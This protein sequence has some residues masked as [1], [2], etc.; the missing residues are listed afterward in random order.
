MYSNPTHI[1]QEMTFTLKKLFTYSIAFFRSN[2]LREGPSEYQRSSAYYI[3]GIKNFFSI[4]CGKLTKFIIFENKIFFWVTPEQ[5]IFFFKI[6]L[7]FWGQIWNFVFYQKIFK[8]QFRPSILSPYAGFRPILMKN[9][10]EKS[11]FINRGNWF[12]ATMA[13]NSQ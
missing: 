9:N 3:W 13:A 1:W 12:L 4:K 2:S 11:Y 7:N 6:L 5:K 8:N 10:F